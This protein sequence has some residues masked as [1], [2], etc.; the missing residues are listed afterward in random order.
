[1]DENSVKPLMLQFQ[2]KNSKITITISYNSNKAVGKTTLLDQKSALH[3]FD[4]ILYVMLVMSSCP[5]DLFK[6]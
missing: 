4:F 5:T 2:Q 1:M 6:L 3:L